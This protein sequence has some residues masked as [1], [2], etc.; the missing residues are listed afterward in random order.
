MSG[1]RERQEEFL[2][3]LEGRAAA[4]VG[5]D[6]QRLEVQAKAL[7]LK[8]ITVLRKRHERLA[9]ALGDRFHGYAKDWIQSEGWGTARAFLRWLA[10]QPLSREDAL[11]VI[12]GRARGSFFWLGRQ[13]WRSGI[14]TA[15]VVRGRVVWK[16]EWQHPG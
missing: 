16:F 15:L 3:H 9:V 4:P 6:G 10:T 1:L 11:A 14:L 13:R 2:R 5:F 8:R 12:A 7:Q